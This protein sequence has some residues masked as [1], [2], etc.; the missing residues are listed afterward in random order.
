MESKSE[1]VPE[2][3]E[4]EISE[5]QIGM[6]NALEKIDPKLK[7]SPSTNILYFDGGSNNANPN[8]NTIVKLSGHSTVK[9]LK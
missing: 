2:L 7:R 3:S 4:S 6:V 9:P 1:K 5:L 8:V